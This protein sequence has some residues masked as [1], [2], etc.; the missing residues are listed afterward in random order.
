MKKLLASTFLLAAGLFGYAG[1]ASAAECG[2]V[3]IA[4]MN[5]QSAEALANLD[6]IILTEGYGCD[7]ELVAGDTVP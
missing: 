4:N 6:K 1:S 5:W 3:T 7:A 2:T